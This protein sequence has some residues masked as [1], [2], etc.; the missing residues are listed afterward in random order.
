MKEEKQIFIEEQ[1]LED[2]PPF[3]QSITDNPVREMIKGRFNTFD[4]VLRLV[5]YQDI[6]VEVPEVVQDPF[7]PEIITN[8]TFSESFQHGFTNTPFVQ[9]EI[10]DAPFLN[11]A[12]YNYSV[13]MTWDSIEVTVS[14]ATFFLAGYPTFNLRFRLAYFD[15]NSKK[16]LSK[17]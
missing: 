16:P 8:V 4:N 13:D 3:Y 11:P 7:V 5:G 12:L 15:I 14:G 10:I 2:I 6:T 9:M 17:L 1:P